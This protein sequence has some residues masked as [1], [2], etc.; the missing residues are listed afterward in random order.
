MENRFN[1]TKGDETMSNYDKYD[2]ANYFQTHLSANFCKGSPDEL[3]LWWDKCKFDWGCSYELAKYCYMH[4]DIWWD[5]ERFRF[6]SE[7]AVKALITNC[8]EHFDVWW[9]AEKISLKL[10]TIDLLLNCSEHFETWYNPVEFNWFHISHLEKQCCEYKHIWQ[11]DYIIHK[12][13]KD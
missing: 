2:F 4:F 5:S 6:K 8:K 7:N 13:L 9:D 1:I 12:T 11:P 10:Y 3:P